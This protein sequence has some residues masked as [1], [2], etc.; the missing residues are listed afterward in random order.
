MHVR[1]DAVLRQNRGTSLIEALIGLLL[2]SICL[3][4]VV[5]TMAYFSSNTADK[6]LRSC[7]LENAGNAIQQLKVNALPVNTTFTCGGLSGTISM[8]QT[9]FP[10]LN[11]C[12]DVTA[13][14]TV[15]AKSVTLQTKVCNIE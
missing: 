12:D 15:G 7:L 11:D 8:S 9:T 2:L 3:L 1:A 10:A 14:A 5:G 13:T 6:S 4:G